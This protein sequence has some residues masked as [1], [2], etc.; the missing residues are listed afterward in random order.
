[1]TDRPWQ[2]WEVYMI[3]SP[4]CLKKNKM[5][6]KQ[7]SQVGN[8]V[9]SQGSGVS[10]AEGALVADPTSQPCPIGV[11]CYRWLCFISFPPSLRMNWGSVDLKVSLLGHVHL[12]CHIDIRCPPAA[13]GWRNSGAVRISEEVFCM[14]SWYC[15]GV[16][17]SVGS[18]WPEDLG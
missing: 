7:S 13:A 5:Q 17:S 10:P 16:S 8:V 15:L 9:G 6:Q 12:F 3:G 2:I 4:S 11:F 18:Q 1:M 14:F